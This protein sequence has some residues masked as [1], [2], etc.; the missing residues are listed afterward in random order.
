MYDIIKIMIYMPFIEKKPIV[1]R[2]DLRTQ[3]SNLLNREIALGHVTKVTEEDYKALYEQ[4]TAKVAKIEAAGL[5]ISVRNDGELR[6]FLITRIDRL[7]PCDLARKFGVIDYSINTDYYGE[8]FNV[9]HPFAESDIG[10]IFFVVEDKQAK[11]RHKRIPCAMFAN[12]NWNEQ[13]AEFAEWKTVH[14]GVGKIIALDYASYGLLHLHDS[15][16]TRW[17]QNTF[18]YPSLIRFIEQP[19]NDGQIFPFGKTHNG[20]IQWDAAEQ[21]A[22]YN[23]S[24][25]A[26]GCVVVALVG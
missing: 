12:M 13:V 1:P 5:S 21:R 23:C 10:Q 7:H 6:A 3:I 26:E 4:A 17:S 8:D 19:T 22:F 18:G 16:L 14:A 11:G 25:A 9:P 24:G 2:T 15:R 20:I